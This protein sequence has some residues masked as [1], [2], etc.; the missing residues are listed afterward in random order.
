MK[1][2]WLEQRK[3]I[4]VRNLVQDFFTAKHYFDDV[5]M[6]YKKKGSLPYS[7][8]DVWIGTETD[9]G[10]LWSLKEQSHRLYRKNRQTISLYENLFDWVV[11]SIFHESMKL[12]EDI[13]QIESY[14]PLLELGLSDNSA[15]QEIAKIIQE[16]YALIDRASSSLKEEIESIDEL[17][18]KGLLH[19]RA[20][21][22]AYKNNAL[23]LRFLI[24][25][26][27]S[28]EA[29][30]GPGAL[31]QILQDMFP[32]GA[33]EAYILMSESCMQN[34]WYNEAQ[35]YLKTAMKTGARHKGLQEHLTAKLGLIS[36]K[37]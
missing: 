30:F 20:M 27:K 13:Y 6:Q 36:G 7:M 18:A 17:F 31:Q 23:L 4:F 33:H 28:T 19:L 32:A 5:R 11:G 25:N 12:K 16:Y 26:K 8:L 24:D 2:Q 10:P 1:T 34:G 3:D 29:V 35:K 15:H 9:K 21:I 22:V 14:K 37:E